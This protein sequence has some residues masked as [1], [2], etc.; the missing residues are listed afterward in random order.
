MEK[1]MD[2]KTT[3]TEQYNKT[4][5]PKKAYERLQENFPY[6][7]YEIIMMRDALRGNIELREIDGKMKEVRIIPAD[8]L[9]TQ[10]GI[11]QTFGRDEIEEILSKYDNLPYVQE[12]INL[13]MQ[14]VS[15]G[16]GN[17]LDSKQCRFANMKFTTLN[18][19]LNAFQPKVTKKPI[20][21]APPIT[22]ISDMDVTVGEPLYIPIIS[23][24]T[25]EKNKK[26]GE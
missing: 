21:T 13:A 11:P 24:D 25:L 7:P 18:A 20:L 6:S 12:Y 5:M 1:E 15:E 14:A 4:Q 9:I 22:D 26:K 19:V 23:I 10:D 8:A 16:D 2:N 3:S 17:K